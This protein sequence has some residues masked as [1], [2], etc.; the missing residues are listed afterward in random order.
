[1]AEVDRRESAASDQV[2]HRFARL[3]LC[4]AAALTLSACGR[5]ENQPGSATPTGGGRASD[6][7]ARDIEGKTVRLSDYLGKQA[8]LLDFCATWCQPCLAELGHLRRI[9]EKEKP[10]GFVILAVSMD[11][12]ET[13][14]EVPSWAHRNSLV[15]P[16]LLDEDSH[17]AAIYNPKKSAPLTVLI[18]KKGDIVY[19]HDGYNPGDEV[20]LEQHVASVLDAH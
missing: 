2:K 19:V 20:A 10:R 4:A 7:T 8:V 18:D 14:A 12:S 1:V 3:A 9:Y 13:V 11:S 5:I 15:F 17:I 16:V 6:F